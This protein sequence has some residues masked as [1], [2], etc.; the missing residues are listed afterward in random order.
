MPAPTSCPISE[1]DRALS[2]YIN[3]R[4]ETLKIRRTLSRYLTTSLR[5]VSTAVKNQHLNHECPQGISATSTNP[6]GLQVSRLEYLQ[7]LRARSQAQARHSELQAALKDLQQRH[8]DENPTQP[9]LDYDNGSTQG[10]VSLLR[11]RRR[12]AE[13]QVIQGSLDK[14][15]TARPSHAPLDLKLHVKDIIGEQPDLPAERLEQLEQPQNDQIWI[16]KLKQEVLD[17]RTSMDRASAAR[18][19]AKSTSQGVPSL[20]QQV[21]ALERARDEIVEWVQGELAKL[22]EDSIFLEDASPI[23][24]P[25]KGPISVDVSSA[26]EKIRNA[27]D[28][29]TASRA[30]LIE[31]YENLQ[32]PPVL[33]TEEQDISPSTSKDVKPDQ[34]PPPQRPITKLIPHLPH[35]TRTA[36]TERS[37]LQ[38]SVYLQAQIASADQEIEDALLRLSGES[39]LLPAGSKDVAAWGKTAAEAEAATKEF[40]E[41]HLQA[42]RQ[43]VS[44]VSTIVELCSLQSKVLGAT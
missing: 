27:Y 22:E 40:V 38:Q 31:S 17:A 35:L 16:F 32:H 26:E 13:L 12:L 9:Q 23:K 37:L 11:Q 10:Y 18:T 41:G 19:K 42:S 2:T 6:P 5:P 44:S 7:A 39:H 8:V 36:N 1:V 20:Q 29:Y 4:E 24:R 28:Q 21:Y 3:S 14:L 43:E 33:Q 15:L 25:A 30:S 34:P